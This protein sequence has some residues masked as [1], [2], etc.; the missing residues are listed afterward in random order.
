M[1]LYHRVM[2]PND[3]DRMA[4]SVDPDQTAPLGAV[5]SGSALF[6]QVYL[7]EN[8][9]SLRQIFYALNFFT[10]ASESGCTR[11]LKIFHSLLILTAIF[12]LFTKTNKQTIQ[13]CILICCYL[14]CSVQ[15]NSDD[16]RTE[17]WGFGNMQTL[18]QPTMISAN[19]GGYFLA[20]ARGTVTC[21]TTWAAYFPITGCDLL[22]FA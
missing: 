15:M 20:I 5:W 1:W 16:K 13:I 12:F 14:T 18:L 21:F 17:S 22:R 8:S 7:Y 9:G 2:S 4:N 11:S 10:I 6:A 3:A 19:D